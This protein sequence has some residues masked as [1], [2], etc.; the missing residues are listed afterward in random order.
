[1]DNEVED[2]AEASV[3]L[4]PDFSEEER[5]I[6][7][8]V[9]PFTMTSVERIVSLA[10]ATKYVAENNIRGDIVECGVWKGGSMMVVAYT[11]QSLGD[12]SRKL[13]LYDTFAGMSAPTERDRRYDGEYAD[14]LLSEMEKNTWLWCYASKDE[15]AANLQSTG[16]PAENVILI[17]GKVEE[18]I[19]QTL[20]DS[21]ALL[22]LDTDW[23]E[24]TKHELTHLY[25]RLARSGVL[26]IDDYGYWQGAKEATDEYFSQLKM[27]PLLQ[28]IDDTG[29]LAIKIEE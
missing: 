3:A 27:K 25:P 9:A 28:R 20:P 2:N 11:L 16:Y 4:P 15:V 14:N 21:I 7:E 26:I 12:T 5:R 18:T 6:C 24:S 29:R 23:Y 17:E 8:A 22:R 10:Q 1:M 19:P 13:Y